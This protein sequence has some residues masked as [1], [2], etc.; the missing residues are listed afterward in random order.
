MS[1]Y[2][3][4]NMIKEISIDRAQLIRQ[5]TVFGI[6]SLDRFETKLK[7]K[8]FPDNKRLVRFKIMYS[9][10]RTFG[11]LVSEDEIWNMFLD[12]ERKA[13]CKYKKVD[14]LTFSEKD[15]TRP[16]VQWLFNMSE[17][18]K[19]WKKKPKV[20]WKMDLVQ[21]MFTRKFLKGNGF[22]FLITLLIL[23]NTLLFLT[24]S[25]FPVGEGILDTFVMCQIILSIYGAG[26]LWYF[27]TL[28]GEW[29]YPFTYGGLVVNFIFMM[30]SA[31]C[32]FFFVLV[33][34]PAYY[35][36]NGCYKCPACSET[37]DKLCF[38]Y[39]KFSRSVN[40]AWAEVNTCFCALEERLRPNEPLIPYG[41]A[42]TYCGGHDCSCEAILDNSF[43]NWSLSQEY[44]TCIY[45]S[46]AGSPLFFFFSGLI[47]ILMVIDFFASFFCCFYLIVMSFGCG[48]DCCLEFVCCG[49]YFKEEQE[50][51]L[52]RAGGLPMIE[53]TIDLH[54]PMS[55]V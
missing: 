38:E 44:Y 2:F 17:S 22:H 46:E 54:I 4:T 52:E 37:D 6:Q 15:I 24:V 34:T 51:A 48:K 45:Y 27:L 19:T 1:G 14:S 36:D 5:S 10:I 23:I 12:E 40:K 31:T 32:C 20:F 30:T 41:K 7:D 3:D 53:K 11:I 50:E 47:F 16:R 13:R 39:S 25:M 21:A 29:W 55:K 35:K 43:E 8:L 42:D 49:I 9:I 26:C 18:Y 28:L 33:M